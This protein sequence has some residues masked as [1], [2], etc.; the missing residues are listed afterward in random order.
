MLFH[1]FFSTSRRN[2]KS[3]TLSKKCLRQG[4]LAQRQQQRDARGDPAFQPPSLPP[5]PRLCRRAVAHTAHLPTDGLGRWR[6]PCFSGE[7]PEAVSE[8][9]VLFLSKDRAGRQGER[10]RFQRSPA[11]TQASAPAGARGRNARPV[12]VT[13]GRSENQP[14]LRYNEVHSANR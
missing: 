1:G 10:V 9:R 5:L 14:Q 13:P 6:D 12:Q 4:I 2:P 8:E 3:R 7:D 11:A